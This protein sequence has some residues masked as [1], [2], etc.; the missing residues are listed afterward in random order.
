MRVKK[1]L[2][3]RSTVEFRSEQQTLLGGLLEDEMQQTK[4]CF[5]G[6]VLF[7]L[8][9]V[10]SLL[11]SKIVLVTQATHIFVSWY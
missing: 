11:H 1:K 3:K 4:R 6:D 5:F 10:L 8:G 7:L 9:V 2:K